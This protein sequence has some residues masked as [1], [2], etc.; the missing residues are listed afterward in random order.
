MSKVLR[1]FISIDDVDCDEMGGI[2]ETIYENELEKLSNQELG[3][4]ISILTHCEEI[5]RDMILNKHLE[6]TYDK[7]F[8]DGK[9]SA[10]D[11]LNEPLM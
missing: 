3:T 4:I 9:L 11:S 8:E 7:G 2:M 1:K 6:E 5:I 10:L